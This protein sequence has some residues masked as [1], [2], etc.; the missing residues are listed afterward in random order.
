MLS[1]RAQDMIRQTIRRTK[2]TKVKLPVVRGGSVKLTWLCR[3]WV[4]TTHLFDVMDYDSQSMGTR[5]APS[6]ALRD[7]GELRYRNHPMTVGDWET[8]VGSDDRLAE[9]L[10]TIL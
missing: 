2:A 8:A 9:L 7:N 6:V 3:G 5:E 4:L 1:P 10:A